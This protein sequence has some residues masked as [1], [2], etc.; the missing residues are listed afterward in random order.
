V[1]RRKDSIAAPESQERA[2]RIHARRR[3]V[4]KTTSFESRRI[5]FAS[6]ARDGS[7]RSS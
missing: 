3:F 1:V 6:S 2:T 4:M 5:N 7:S